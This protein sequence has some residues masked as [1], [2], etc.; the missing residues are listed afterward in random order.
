MDSHR[1]APAIL[2]APALRSGPLFSPYHE[3]VGSLY[4]GAPF[5]SLLTSLRAGAIF[6]LFLLALFL[7]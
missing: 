2:G 5:F 4:Y 3:A 7:R 6:P 1:D